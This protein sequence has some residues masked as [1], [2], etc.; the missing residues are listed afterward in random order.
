MADNTR[1]AYLQSPKSRDFFSIALQRPDR[2]FRHI[3]RY[4]FYW[5]KFGTKRVVYSGSVAICL[6]LLWTWLQMILS[7]T[8]QILAGLNV[9][10][11][12]NSGPFLYDMDNKDQMQLIQWWSY[13]LD[14][15][16]YTTT[17][18]VSVVQ[19]GLCVPNILAGWVQRGRPLFLMQSNKHQAS[20]NAWNSDAFWL[21]WRV[22]S[23]GCKGDDWEREYG[24]ENNWEL[25]GRGTRRVF[26]GSRSGDSGDSL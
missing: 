11:N 18:A 12:F 8:N 17:V 23:D 15:A 3:F 26:L 5:F 19:S 7:L 1:G 9:M 10:S 14:R 4:V 24:D 25:V 20:K 6:M 13:Q 22:A 2:E 21:I 16:L